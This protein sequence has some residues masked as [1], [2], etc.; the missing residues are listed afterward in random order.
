M[1][2]VLAAELAIFVHFKS[3]RVI[4]FVFLCVIVSLL[5]NAARQSYFD[6]VFFFSHFRHLPIKFYFDRT[7]F[8]PAST[9]KAA[10]R[11]VYLPQKSFA[12]P[13]SLPEIPAAQNEHEK[14]APTNRG[15]LIISLFSFS[16][17]IFLIF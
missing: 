2:S 7:V 17:K 9:A 13:D 12:F 1:K 4:F 15:R 11:S 14:I 8:L 5:A 10:P 16:V 3:V 6:S